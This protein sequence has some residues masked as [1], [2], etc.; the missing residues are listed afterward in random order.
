[1]DAKFIETLANYIQKTGSLAADT[2]DLI[3][4]QQ[5]FLDK[6]VQQ[7]QASVSAVKK[8]AADTALKLASIRLPKSGLPLI[9]GGDEV[10]KAA[11]MLTDLDTSIGLLDLVL[12]TVQKDGQRQKQASLEPGRAVASKRSKS[13]TADEQ[14]AI[15]CGITLN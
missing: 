5:Q 8:R 14:L 9:A 12:D 2:K 15:D 13:L 1:M 7:K 3:T 4:R 10:K 11:L 6:D